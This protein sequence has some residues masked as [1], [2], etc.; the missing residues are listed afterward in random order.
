MAIYRNIAEVVQ[1][2][3]SNRV[4]MQKK[5]TIA[6]IILSLVILGILTCSILTYSKLY[7]KEQL[8]ERMI[9]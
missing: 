7:R 3:E 8:D 2:Q 6:E 5:A 4:M 1:K 9:E